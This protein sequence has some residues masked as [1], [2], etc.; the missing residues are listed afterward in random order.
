MLDDK[1]LQDETSSRTAPNFGFSTASGNEIVISEESLKKARSILNEV[2]KEEC[3]SEIKTVNQKHSNPFPTTSTAKADVGFTTASGNTVTVSEASIKK[4]KRILDDGNC[5]D[6]KKDVKPTST[7]AKEDISKSSVSC[8]TRSPSQE[9][10]PNGNDIECQK[11]H[12]RLSSEIET[13]N[14]RIM[15]SFIDNT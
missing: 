12:K 14:G 7:T 11:M 3:R 6:H 2:D 9:K 13:E 15:T 8:K 10:T 4:A 1:L 5:D